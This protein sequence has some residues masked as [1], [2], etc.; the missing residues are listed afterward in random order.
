V[1]L[2]TVAVLVGAGCASSGPTHASGTTRGAAGAG[3]IGDHYF[4]TSGNGGYDVT[5]YDIRIGYSPD[6][7]QIRATTTVE[8]TATRMLRS[9]ELDLAGFTVDRVTVDGRPADVSRHRAKIVV[10]PS[11]TLAESR[12][13]VTRVTYHGVPHTITDPSEPKTAD[14]GQLGWTRTSDGDV[15]VV[16]EPVGARTWFPGNDHPSDKATFA[17]TVTVPDSVAVAAN[18]TLHRR[19]APGR[20]QAWEWTMDQPMATY[21]ATVVIAPMRVQR[22]TSAAGVPIR[23]YFRDDAFGFDSQSFTKTGTMI[24]YFSSLFGAYPFGAYGAVV[25]QPKIGYALETQTMSVF[26]SDML[27]TDLDAEMTVAHELAHQWFGDSVGIRRWADIWLNEG[28]ATYAQYLW[29]AHSNSSFDLDR[30]MIDLR[31]SEGAK[32]TP[33]NN[34][35]P[36]GLFTGSIYERGALTLHALR[37][38]IG[39]TKF[40]EIAKQ[41]NAKY[42]YSTATTTDF[43]AL[44]SAVFG[45]DLTTF[46]H[47]WL[48]ADT[49]P[50]LP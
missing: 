26:G 16:S 35:G 2:V 24:D 17:V 47:A 28:W 36:D 49:I 31:A 34:P 21:L 40:F 25:V 13:F 30:T 14:A 50:R 37:R 18:G 6:R 46:F 23:N 3:T 42:R 27:G 22:S 19:A 44:T 38:T 33:P 9:F 1:A 29:A 12:R 48:D 41:W 5:H 7:P 8:S 11:T 4:P 10:H 45:R 20:R 15:F 43:I 39:D 32:L